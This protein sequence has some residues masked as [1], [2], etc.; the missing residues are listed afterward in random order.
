MAKATYSIAIV[1]P[2]NVRLWRG[3]WIAGEK[4]PDIER[5][6][7]KGLLGQNELQEAGNLEDAIRLVQKK[8]PNKTIMREGSSKVG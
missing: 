3:F 6:A 1:D 7:K 4:S 8:H 5:A 2:E